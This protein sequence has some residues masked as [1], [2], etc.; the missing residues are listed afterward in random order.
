MT[1]A[2]LHQGSD[3]DPYPGQPTAGRNAFFLESSAFFYLFPPSPVP[4]PSGTTP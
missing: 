1:S 3:R 2:L 4:T